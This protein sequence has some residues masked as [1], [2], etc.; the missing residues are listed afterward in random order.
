MNA[1]NESGQPS[2]VASTTSS[3]ARAQGLQMAKKIVTS[4]NLT[5]RIMYRVV[6]LKTISFRDMGLL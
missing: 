4:G 6:V 2:I 3:C 5:Y 1:P